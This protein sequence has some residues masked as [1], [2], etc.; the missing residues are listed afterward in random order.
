MAGTDQA[1]VAEDEALR[2]GVAEASTTEVL[3]PKVRARGRIR[4]R[5]GVGVRVRVRVRVRVWARR[6]SHPWQLLLQLLLLTTTNY[7]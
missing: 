1:L 4:G 6:S 3:A 2:A 7:Y 5:V